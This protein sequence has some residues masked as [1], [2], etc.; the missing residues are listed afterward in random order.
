[1][2]PG[3]KQAN[4]QNTPPG[5]T[6]STK[7][8]SFTHTRFLTFGKRNVIELVG[9]E[10]SETHAAIAIVL[11]VPENAQRG[12]FRNVEPGIFT[13]DHSPRVSRLGHRLIFCN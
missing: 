5:T 11:L 4:Q 7:T 3:I 12:L 2:L 6:Y 13:P 9:L 8:A 10:S 1:M